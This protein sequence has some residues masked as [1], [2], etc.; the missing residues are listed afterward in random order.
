MRGF[1]ID[2]SQIDMVVRNAQT[3]DKTVFSDV[4]PMGS[5]LTCNKL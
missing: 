2:V 1:Q 3:R 5:A 4:Y